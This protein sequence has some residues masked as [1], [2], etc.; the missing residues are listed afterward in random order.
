MFVHKVEMTL[1]LESTLMHQMKRKR[2]TFATNV[3][4]CYLSLVFKLLIISFGFIYQHRDDF[5]L[6]MPLHL[7]PS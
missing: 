5:L 1:I 3:N 4:I 2:H 7:S 6:A